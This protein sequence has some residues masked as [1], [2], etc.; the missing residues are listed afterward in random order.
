MLKQSENMARERPAREYRCRV[1]GEVAQKGLEASEHRSAAYKP[2]VKWFD[3]AAVPENHAAYTFFFL[4]ESLIHREE[5]YLVNPSLFERI[6][7]VLFPPIR[8]R[9]NKELLAPI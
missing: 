3:T 6:W 9:V 7:S 4:F 1:S 8:S 5:F 2:G